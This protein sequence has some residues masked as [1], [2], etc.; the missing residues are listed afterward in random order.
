[1]AMYIV[2]SPSRIHCSVAIW[3]TNPVRKRARYIH[4]V[5][6]GMRIRTMIGASAIQASGP[7][8]TGV[9]EAHKRPAVRHDSVHAPMLAG[10]SITGCCR[11]RAAAMIRWTDGSMAGVDMGDFASMRPA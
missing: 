6:C 3:L 9:N 7:Q 5:G 11:D 10:R 8:S 4:L 2:G 1:M